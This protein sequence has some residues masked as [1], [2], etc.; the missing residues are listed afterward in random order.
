MGMSKSRLHMK[1][2]VIIALDQLSR[3]IRRYNLETVENGFDL[4][5]GIKPVELP[6]SQ[7]EIDVFSVKVSKLALKQHR[8]EIDSGRVPL[9]MYIF[10]LMPFRHENTI[11]SVSFVQK[12]INDRTILEEENEVLIRRF[13]NATNR[14]HTGLQDIHRRIGHGQNDW[15]DEDI[16]EVLPFSCDMERAYEHDVVTVFQNFLR[17]RSVPEIPHD[18]KHSKSD[19]T[20]FPII[21]SLSGGVDSMVIASVLSYL[22]RVEMFSL[23]VIAVH[24]DYANRPESGAE[25]RYV[26]K[27]CNELGIEYRCRVIDEV[28]RGVTARDEYEKV[29]R[30]ARYNFYKCV[31]DE[32]QAQ[33]GSKAPVLLGHHKGDLRENVLSNSM[34]GCGPLDLSGMSDVGTVEKVVVWRPL[35]PLEKDAVFDFAH[36]YGVPYFKDTTPLWSTRGKLRNKL[37]PLLCEMYGEGSM[38][39]LSNLAV[40]SDAAKHLFLASLEPFFARVKSFPMGLSFDTSEYRHHGIFF[41]RFVLRQVLHSHGRGMFTDKCIQSFINRISTDKRKTGWLQCRRDYAVYLDSDGTVYVLHPQY[42]PF[43]KKDQYDCTNQHVAIGK[44]TLEFGSW[45]IKATL[46]PNQPHH[47]LDQKPFNN[48][49]EFMRGDFSYFLALPD[50]TLEKLDVFAGGGFT[51]ATRPAAW[52]SVDLKIESTLPLIAKFP[53]EDISKKSPLVR[54]DYRVQ[55]TFVEHSTS[56]E[57]SKNAREILQKHSKDENNDKA[58]DG[59]SEQQSNL[60][61]SLIQPFVAS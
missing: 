46:V 53:K 12:C 35:L 30:D 34:K 2:A 51:K 20:T 49:A 11:E 55:G 3:H 5:D 47:A 21:V 15:S 45:T 42:F 32:F 31:Q 8:Q 29:A 1:A 4:V 23:R 16:L 52:K 38:L 44:D 24:I 28:T 54:L 9:G 26:E 19:K 59:S 13:R 61:D 57:A 39:N 58:V 43:A 22:R 41:W 18:S 60:W 40:E 50:A 56:S 7:K 48:M 27:Y 33:D 36:Q 17:A 37:L 10:M 14:R 25:A 6:K